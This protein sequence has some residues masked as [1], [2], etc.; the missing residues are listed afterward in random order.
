MTSKYLSSTDL[1]IGNSKL[2]DTKLSFPVGAST[3]SSSTRRSVATCK[4]LAVS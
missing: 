3:S 1:C 2:P 4:R